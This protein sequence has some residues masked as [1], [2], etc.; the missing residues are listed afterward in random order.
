MDLKVVLKE[1][2]LEMAE[3]DALILWEKVVL[4]FIIFKIKES[5]TPIDDVALPFMDQ[6]DKAVKEQLHKI[7]PSS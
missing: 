3:K 5:K 4:P 7:D 2:G 1:A 6:V